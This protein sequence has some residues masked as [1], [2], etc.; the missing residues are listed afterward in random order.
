MA[1]L[2]LRTCQGGKTGVITTVAATPDYICGIG[3]ATG[4]VANIRVDLEASVGVSSLVSNSLV[5]SVVRHINPLD[6]GNFSSGTVVYSQ[7]FSIPAIITATT[8][9][10]SAADLP[11]APAS[12]QLNYALYVSATLAGT[13][14]QG[15]QNLIGTAVN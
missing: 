13:S 5:I 14:Y 7:T 12:G 4:V 8:F 3:L 1:F 2:D 11:P 10:L 15:T 9:S 6:F